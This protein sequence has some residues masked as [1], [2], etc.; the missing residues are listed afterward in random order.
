MSETRLTH[1]SEQRKAQAVALQASISSQVEALRN[2]DQWCRFLRFAQSFHQYSLNNV[3][4]ILSQRP[5]A[6]RV[7]GYR[8]WQ[9]LGRQVRTGEKGI[10]IFGYRKQ[11]VS[12]ELTYPG[13]DPDGDVAAART[14]THFPIVTVFDITQTDPTDEDATV[15]LSQPVIGEDDQDIVPK[16]MAHLIAN[17]WT[18]EH[19]R[20]SR[21]LNGYTDP[22]K[23]RVTLSD[24]LSAK[25]SAKTLI[26]ETAHIVL[27]HIADPDE[28]ELH[29]GLAETEA[30]SV[31][32]V[33]AGLAGIDT[34]SYSIGY[35]AGWSYSDTVTISSTAGRVLQAAHT[36]AEIILPS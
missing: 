21:G 15:T 23:K 25:Q 7:A 34:A 14:I 26:H 10:H 13:N 32:Y 19:E 33:V 18:V 35:I 22:T 24:S 11:E 4:L 17:G 9:A 36:I 28:Y 6:T 3:L 2:S 5:D 20:L 8:A 30:E 31:A 1:N 27:D 29:R 12:A 16:L